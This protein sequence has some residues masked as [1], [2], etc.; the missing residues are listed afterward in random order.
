MLKDSK[1]NNI[2]ECREVSRSLLGD[3]QIH[4]VV[5]VGDY[6][7]MNMVNYRYYCQHENDLSA[8]A[9]INCKL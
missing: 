7:V 4:V 1:H 6:P 3:M 9:G 8:M 5:A 2:S